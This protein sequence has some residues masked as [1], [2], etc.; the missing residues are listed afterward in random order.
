MV[1]LAEPN[2]VLSPVSSPSIPTTKSKSVPFLSNGCTTPSAVASKN[3]AREIVPSSSP[4]I[5]VLAPEEP[6]FVVSATSAVL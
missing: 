5:Y 2:W 6:K 3:P 4:D 1:K